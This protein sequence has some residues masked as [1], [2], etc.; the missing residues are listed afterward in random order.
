MGQKLFHSKFS[1]TFYYSEQLEREKK[2]KNLPSF[3]RPIRKRQHALPADS[4]VRGMESIEWSLN[5]I[6]VLINFFLIYVFCWSLRKFYT[7]L[8]HQRTSPVCN[9]FFL[10]RDLNSIILDPKQ[11]IPTVNTSLSF[12]TSYLEQKINLDLRKN[13]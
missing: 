10:V 11:S 3:G 8:S 12:V 13:E 6:S 7:V 5:R 4:P 2:K 9:D 1:W